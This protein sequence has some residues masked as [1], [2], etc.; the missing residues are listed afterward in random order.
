MRVR[1][2]LCLVG[3]LALAALPGAGVADDSGA[4]EASDAAIDFER[5][6]QPIFTERCVDCHGVETSEAGLRLDRRSR[7]LAG[8][9]SGVV[10]VPEEP[11]D[12]LLFQ[13]VSG[14]DPESV[15]PPDG[16]P[17]SD[18]QVAVIRGWIEQGA[19]WPASADAAPERVDHW[20]F[21]PI[22]QGDFPQLNVA[23]DAEHEIDAFVRARLESAGVQP[24]SEADRHTLIKRLYYDL[25]GLV[26]E[27]DA[28]DQFVNDSAPDAWNQLVD[29][30][31]DSP[32]FGERWGRHWLDT[33]RYADSDGYEKDRPRYNAWKYRDWVIDAINADMPFDQFTT[34]QLA[35]DLLPDPTPDQLLATAFHRQTLTNTEGGTDQ[36]EFRVAAIMDRVETLG[37]AWLGLTVGC[38]RCHSHKYDPLTQH[39]YY[40]LF[41]FFNN[42]DEVNTTVATSEESMAAYTLAKAEYDSRLAE[43]LEPLAAAKDALRPE[44]ADWEATERARV[45]DAAAEFQVIEATRVESVESATLETLD[46]G[47]F[48]VS[49]ER[50]VTDIYNITAPLTSENVTAFRLEVLQHESLPA[51]G[52]GRADHG[53]FV[54]SEITFQAVEEG[55]VDAEPVIMELRAAR[56][57]FS[58]NNFDPAKAID[59]TED[60]TG[61]AISPQMGKSHF[62]IFY[63]SD[64]SIAA[65]ADMQSPVVTARLS[66]QY[67]SSPH[68]IGCFRLS[69]M[70]GLDEESLGL[71]ENVRTL[72]TVESGERNEQQQ[73]ELF[74]YFAGL[75]PDVRSHQEAVDE[76]KKTEPFKPE[77]T[78][79]V[80]QERPSNPR[81]THLLKRGDFLQPLVEVQPGVFSVL[82]EI[83]A[84]EDGQAPSRLDLA[85]WIVS[86]ENPLTPR[87]AVNH[88]WRH[89]FGRGLVNTANDF[90]VRGETPTHPELLDWLAGEYIRLGWS[91]KALIRT[92]V[93]SQTYRRSS[94]HRTELSEVDPQNQLLYRQNRVR[95]EAETVRDL[96]L[97]ASGLLDPRVGG[98][99]VFPTLPPG[100]AELSYANNFRWGD[101]TW[102]DRPDRPGGVAPRDDVYRRGVYTFFKRTAAHPTLVTFDCPDANVTCVERTSSNTPLQALATL[103]NQVFVNAARSL[104][105]RGL[106]VANLDHTER[107]S[108]IFRLCIVRPST[109][110]ERNSF[111]G[112]FQHAREY[113]DQHPDAATAFAADST[114]DGVSTAEYAAWI[115]VS[116]MIMNLDEFIT[117][118]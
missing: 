110:S 81:T 90:G 69:A 53:N 83:Q 88:V 49:G 55:A 32:H 105:R 73:L 102:N 117:R 22:Q 60:A 24:S 4:G 112:F 14:V 44:F 64:E 99:S 66:Q 26:P 87:V 19:E 95:V 107:I 10:I 18:Q 61:W 29:E 59:G 7:A 98:P 114:P 75:N 97:S 74:D 45:K 25:L 78:V 33:A 1:C 57:D 16:E 52:P 12:S 36:E 108:L 91:R 71:P 70:S 2:L 50:P 40:E 37:T 92:I 79:R 84:G 28:V 82:H 100:I 85:H 35:G 113:Y 118:E 31:L 109:E 3:L 23:G 27:S 6:V 39:E 68:T 9:D 115:A 30:L 86:A 72:L 54:L 5:D 104:A 103:N 76:F 15:M 17:L 41:A 51:G 34:E 58:Q 13:Y 20:A 62:A 11:D 116:R 38:A 89:L 93:L 106:D 96:Y 56:A 77:M 111:V 94:Q 48:L 101:S 67:E 46:D 42:G 8:G 65:L 47:A 63:L 21:Q 43:L 80:I